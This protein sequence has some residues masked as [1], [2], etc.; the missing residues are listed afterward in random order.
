MEKDFFTALQDLGNDSHVEAPLLIE[1]VKSAIVKAA[2][3]MYPACND[4]DFR[5]EIDPE[6]QVLEI[7]LIRTVVEAYAVDENEINLEDAVKINPGIEPGDTIEQK[8]DISKFGRAAAQSAKQSIKGDLRDI[9]RER[10]LAEFED[11]EH[12]CISVMVTQVEPA[13]TV[14]VRYHKTE[15]YLFP[16]EQIPGE[17]LREGQIIKVYIT[18][19]ANR[20]KKPIIKISRSRSELVRCIFEQEIPEIEDGLVEVKAVSREAGF[21]AKVAVWSNDP[22]VDAIGACLGRQSSRINAIAR[23]VNGEKID[24]IPYSDEPNLFIANALLPARVLRVD[25]P[26]PE[27]RACTAIVPDEQL[28]LAIGNRG[29]NAKLAA[30]L[31][32]YKIDIRPATEA[33]H[34]TLKIPEAALH[35]EEGFRFEEDIAAEIARG[36]AE[37]ETGEKN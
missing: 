12:E 27:E 32:G 9:V 5:V 11:L 8:L 24:I 29:Q 22:N 17:M 6:R 10:I 34:P 33:V 31:T 3:R 4:E 2:R 20:Q 26:D 14:T 15:L 28:S 19:I 36:S 1:K 7:Y 23:E 13:G 18:A 37:E 21:R 16:N 30:R 35:D 25:I